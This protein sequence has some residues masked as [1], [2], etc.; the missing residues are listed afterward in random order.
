M[1]RLR[2]YLWGTNFRFVSDHK[3]LES[4]DKIAE[5]NPRVQR[6]LEFLTS[7]NCTLEHRKGSAN[8]K[9]FFSPACL[10]LRRSST[11]AVPADLLRPM[12]NAS[13]SSTRTAYLLAD[14]SPC[15]SVWVGYRPPNRVLAWV[16]SHSPLTIF[17]IFANT[18]PE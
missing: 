13:F 5:H 15:V 1:N 2:K 7:Y 11:A 4:L 12:K 10:C 9:A 8:G 17:K 18:G 14:L 3:A 16:G 6:W